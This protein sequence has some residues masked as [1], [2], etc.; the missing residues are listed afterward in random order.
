MTP[1]PGGDEHTLGPTALIFNVMRFATHDG[2]GI[3]TTVFLKGCPLACCWCHNPEGQNSEPELL[4]FEE[5][6]RH[7]GDCLTACPEHAV[8]HVGGAVRTS[9][10]CRHCGRCAEVCVAEARRIAG[11]RFTVGGLL[12]EIERDLVFFEESGGGLT[13]SGG[14][15]MAQPHFVSALLDECR[16]RRIHTAIETC[17]FAESG[18]FLRVA[19]AADLVLFDLKLVDPEKHR[20][21]TGASNQPILHNLEGLVARGRAVTVRIPVVPG[22]NDAEEDIGQFAGYLARLR[23]RQVELLP[24]HQ[25]GVEKYRR[26]G[27][28]YRL[29]QTPLPAA[30]DLERFRDGLARAGL[31]V[32]VGGRP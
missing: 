32:T 15:P 12:K 18:A 6:C 25:T 28:T 11:R 16:E 23:V 8:E 27:S 19:L 21:H 26:L 17:G 20:R 30:P 13:L 3:R 29:K 1:A 31:R 22:I 2:P 7:C 24:Y 4:Y 9:A 14:E 5:R 10:A